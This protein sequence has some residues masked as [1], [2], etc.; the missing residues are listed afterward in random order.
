MLE[1]IAIISLSKKI[2]RIVIEKNLKPTK[3]IVIMVLLWISLEFFGAIAGTIFFGEDFVVY[4]FALT[5]AG[6]G[7]LL[8]YTIANNAKPKVIYNPSIESFGE[9][10]VDLN[11]E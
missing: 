4:L 3:Y 1:I 8:G 5:G 10:E 2:K 11:Y 7:A 9:K 6:L